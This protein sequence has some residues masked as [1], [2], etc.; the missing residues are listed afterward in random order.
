MICNTLVSWQL[1]HID[2][3]ALS[4]SSL[5]NELVSDDF[6]IKILHNESNYG[7]MHLFKKLNISFKVI[8]A[9]FE[10]EDLNESA[11]FMI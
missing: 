3:S 4:A 1:L 6:L 5:I 8:R 10:R 7:S 9:I 2:I 11:I